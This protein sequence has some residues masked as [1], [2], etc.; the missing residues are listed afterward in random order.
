MV[1]EFAVLSGTHRR[2]RREAQTVGGTGAGASRQGGG[3]LGGGDIFPIER[4][5]GSVGEKRCDHR[6][7]A[8]ASRAM[9]AR[10]FDHP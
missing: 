6:A 7:D 4:I 8:D 3:S 9:A 10:G 1:G 5:R 2:R